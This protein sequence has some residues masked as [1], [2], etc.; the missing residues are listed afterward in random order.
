MQ[1]KQMFKIK[2]LY[3]FTYGC[4]SVEYL[5]ENKQEEGNRSS[6][7]ERRRGRPGRQ[8]WRRGEFSPQ[9]IL[10]QVY[11]LSVPK[12]YT[13]TQLPVVTQTPPTVPHVPS[14][15][16][17]GLSGCSPLSLVHLQLSSRPSALK[18]QFRCLLL[19][20]GL[21]HPIDGESKEHEMNRQRV[22]LPRG[23]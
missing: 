16:H 17:A 4:T 12:N 11:I 20:E 2:I 13:H 5:W 23:L 7:R 15:A 1:K 8:G 3:I 21:A 19:Q 18:T 9:L 14:F 22:R 6:S 10:Y